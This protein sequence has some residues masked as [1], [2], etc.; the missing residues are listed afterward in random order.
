MTMMKQMLIALGL[1]VGGSVVHAQNPDLP[2]AK[3]VAAD[4]LLVMEEK[5]LLRSLQQLA[6]GLA[7]GETQPQAKQE[8]LMQILRYQLMLN[9]LAP[10][11][12][13]VI[14]HLSPE[15]SGGTTVTNNLGGRGTTAQEVRLARLERMLETLLTERREAEAKVLVSAPTSVAKT[16]SEQTVDTTALK[17]M[18]AIKDLEAKLAQ[19]EALLKKMDANPQIDLKLPS[20]SLSDELANLSHNAQTIIHTT[21]TIEVTKRVQVATDFKRS[22]YFNVASDR[23]DPLAARTL[24]E[25]VTFLAEYPEAQLNLSG[26]ASPEGNAAYNEQLADRRLSTVIAYLASKGVDRTR[27]IADKT[28]I[29]RSRSGFQLARRVDLSLREK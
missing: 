21:D 14:Y 24:D 8:D 15:S 3:T 4:T 17:Q 22:V 27:L 16:Q 29:D 23:I 13:T 12:P 25:V 1:T 26:F 10:K 5:A 11:E 18:Q 28:G 19:T 6:D 9:L 2:R 7:A 20:L